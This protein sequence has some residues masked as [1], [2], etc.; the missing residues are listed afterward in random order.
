MDAYL[1]PDDTYA[2]QGITGP[3]PEAWGR[4]IAWVDGHPGHDLIGAARAL[5]LPWRT[6]E[7]ILADPRAA[8]Y[9]SARFGV[10]EAAARRTVDCVRRL[11]EDRTAPHIIQL[12]ACL[13]LISRYLGEV[14]PDICSVLSGIDFKRMKKGGKTRTI[15]TSL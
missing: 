3:M 8:D 15:T 2:L 13:W 11:S 4:V 1:A 14:P 6:V 5:G 10:E 7:A 12:A 9:R